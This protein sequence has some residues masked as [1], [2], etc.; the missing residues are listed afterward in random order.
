MWEI[1]P[2][3]GRLGRIGGGEGGGGLTGDPFA[4][5]KYFDLTFSDIIGKAANWTTFL[6]L[7]SKGNYKKNALLKN[8]VNVDTNSY[9]F[10]VKNHLRYLNRLK[11][12]FSKIF[13]LIHI[14]NLILRIICLTTLGDKMENKLE[15]ADFTKNVY[16][17][18]FLKWRQG[19]KNK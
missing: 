3:G 9:L 6:T 15:E 4:E 1:R 2:R 19:G 11:W 14:G 13:F 7:K 18:I 12:V 17:T 10:D 16:V 5:E 8:Q